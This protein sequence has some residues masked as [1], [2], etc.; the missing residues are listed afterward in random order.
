M[1]GSMSNFPS[2]PIECLDQPTPKMYIHT[3]SVN[4]HL[5]CVLFS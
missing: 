1:V 4:V 2:P 3:T 5:L